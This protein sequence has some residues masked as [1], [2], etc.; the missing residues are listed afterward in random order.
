MKKIDLLY[1]YFKIQKEFF[2]HSKYLQENKIDYA[3]WKHKF[4]QLLKSKDGR[5]K[6]LLVAFLDCEITEI[7]H[8]ASYKNSEYS[9][10]LICVIKNEI[11]KIESFMEH[12]R[13]LGIEK[14]VFL[15]NLSTDGTTEY[16]CAQEDTIVYSS[17]QEYSSARRVAWINRLLA[18]H[19]INRW[20]MIVDSDELVTYVG[21]EQ[22]RISEVVE[23]AVKNKY[24]RILGFMLDM[25]SESSLFQGVEEK[26]YIEKCRF[27]DVDSYE[28]KRMHR[29]L[30]IHGG[31]RK[32]VFGVEQVLEKY[33]LFFFGTNIFVASSHYIIP[34]TTEEEYPIWFAICHYKFV[35]EKDLD[36]VKEAVL[37]ENYAQNS[38]VYKQYLSV[39]ETSK[40]VT[41]YDSQVSTELK[42]S[43]SLKRV[44]F[45]Q[46]PF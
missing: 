35:D 44:P 15:D 18:L 12:Y 11:N 30:G 37:K 42:S 45:L 39:I 6:E 26:D 33:P 22:H 20:C 4:I 5:T 7:S 46:E 32:R 28:V 17:E 16:L 8:N 34:Y 10:V 2:A 36:K 9:P 25:Y 14:F 27:F 24:D 40:N 29:G 31:P 21:C 38:I 1:L 19:G 3:L 13:K 23:K 43:E 41:F